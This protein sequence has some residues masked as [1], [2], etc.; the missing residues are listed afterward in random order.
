MEIMHLEQRI[1]EL[2]ESIE[3]LTQKRDDQIAAINKQKIPV[4]L[5]VK[6]V[7]YL[8]ILRPLLQIFILICVRNFLFVN[9][10]DRRCK[11]LV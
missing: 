7:Q 6:Y 3:M 8:V 10:R 2:Q 11:T 9:F 4:N 1:G 5:E